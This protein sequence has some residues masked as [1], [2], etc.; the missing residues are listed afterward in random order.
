MSEEETNNTPEAE[1]PEEAVQQAPRRRG[2]LILVILFLLA[3]VF[4]GAIVQIYA[5]LSAYKQSV[6][7]QLNVMRYPSDDRYFPSEAEVEDKLDLLRKRTKKV[8]DHLAQ[9]EEEFHAQASMTPD[10]PAEDLVDRLREEIETKLENLP[11]SSHAEHAALIEDQI[12]Y[13]HKALEQDARRIE[14]LENTIARLREEL[15][16]SK[17]KAAAESGALQSLMLLQTRFENGRAFGAA[18][19]A[20]DDA[21]ATWERFRNEAPASPEQMLAAW[22]QLHI[23]EM[24]N[25]PEEGEETTS[26]WN[27]I[28]EKFSRM[29]SVK[30][31]DEAPAPDLSNW[32]DDPWAS[33]ERAVNF[34]AAQE[35]S[36]DAMTLWLDNA[37]D[38]LITQQTLE[39]RINEEL[40]P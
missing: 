17:N 30:K 6:N 9:W 24:Q 27:R 4:A 10:I 32:E 20:V 21:P 3:A 7:N 13:F 31:L 23:E 28:A 25:I 5:E 35:E 26:I 18:L 29:V 33:L 14:K 11:Q 40:A 1:A 8:E 39:A 12:S 22:E 15:K 34:T 38:L 19:E 16:R 37:R 36:S 2:K